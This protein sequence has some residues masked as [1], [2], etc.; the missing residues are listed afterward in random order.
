MVHGLGFAREATTPQP[1]ASTP[2]AG[3]QQML[4]HANRPWLLVLCGA[5]LRREG[6]GVG[7]RI[8]YQ[9]VKVQPADGLGFHTVLS[10]SSLISSALH[11]ILNAG[12]CPFAR[13]IFV[14]YAG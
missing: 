2:Q 8:H 6:G 12:E 13:L 1:K 14:Y 11:N 7:D 5:D 4:K 10:P 9:R 3:E